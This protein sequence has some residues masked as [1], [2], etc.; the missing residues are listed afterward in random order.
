M[1]DFFAWISLTALSR[2]YFIPVHNNVLT[3]VYV[4]V[5]GVGGGGWGVPQSN[6]D[7]RTSE[8]CTNHVLMLQFNFTF[9]IDLLTIQYFIE[10]AD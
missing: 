8:I 1:T 4:Y 6:T 2:T 7:M 5:G 3:R 9:I 10:L